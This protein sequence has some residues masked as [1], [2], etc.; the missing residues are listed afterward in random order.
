MVELLLWIAATWAIFFA[1]CGSLRG[2]I[3]RRWKRLAAF[4]VV[5]AV[6]IAFGIV[7]FA[8][9]IHGYNELAA[10]YWISR[11]AAEPDS[12]EKEALVRRVALTSPHHGWHAASRAIATVED[13]KQRCRL[14]TLLAGLPGVQNRG[15]LGNEARDECNADLPKA[16][17]DSKG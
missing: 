4:A 17:S 8:P 16:A 10:N 1:I 3:G 9:P 6:L 2:P 13:A 11:A 7:F 15:R 12:A 5:P 14:R